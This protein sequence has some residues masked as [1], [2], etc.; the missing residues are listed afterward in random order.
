MTEPITRTELYWRVDN[1]FHEAYPD[2]PQQLSATD[3]AHQSWREAWIVGRD[4]MLNQEVDR[5]YWDRY[6]DAPRQ[7]DDS[8]PEWEKWRVSWTNIWHEVMD[9][10][11]QPGE[12]QLQNAVSDDGKLDLSHIK[13][14]VTEQL[15]GQNK[16]GMVLQDTFEEAVRL[17]ERLCDEVGALAM[18]AGTV[19]G[20]WK[21]KE[22]SV[23]GL[24]DEKVTIQVTGWWG[25]GY[26][27]GVAE[28]S[29]SSLDSQNH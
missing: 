22:D 23:R 6:P 8:S 2:A 11:P 16:Q 18:A 13:A 10:A 4:R 5:V 9:N 14:S 21:S 17:A 26:F 15:I 3:P 20:S 7:L 28:I 24:G 19:D 25:D 29:M 27:T 1:W 12:V